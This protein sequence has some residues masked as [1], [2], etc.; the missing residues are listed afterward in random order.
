[1]QYYKY[2]FNAMGTPCEIQMFAASETLAQQASALV[3]HD[4]NR[5]EA[6]Y[7]RY[8]KDSFLSK[9]NRKA[10]FISLFF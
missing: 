9:I 8:R 6:L 3:I 4:V 1:M 10:S 7:S 2:Q 5:L